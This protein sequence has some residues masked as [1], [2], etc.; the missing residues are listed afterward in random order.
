MK[1]LIR[2]RSGETLDPQLTRDF[3]TL[4][5]C[6]GGELLEAGRAVGLDVASLQQVGDVPA[7][8]VFRP[9]TDVLAD[10]RAF[11]EALQ[12]EELE[13]T[14]FFL[15]PGDVSASFLAEELQKL[16]ATL[17]A[18]RADEVAFTGFL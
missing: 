15:G 10:A 14:P 11:A 3:G 18:C 7:R 2:T 6:P 16:V 1:I 4:L 12:G 5:A 17:E 8:F 9:R 13:L